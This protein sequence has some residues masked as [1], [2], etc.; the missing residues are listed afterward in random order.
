MNNP[1][2]VIEAR[3]SRIEDLIYDLK[4]QLI[5]V[6]PTYHPEQ[7]LTI[8]QAAEFLNITVPTK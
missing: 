2:A 4:H 6:E 8:Q 7:L 5:K 3:L 1:F